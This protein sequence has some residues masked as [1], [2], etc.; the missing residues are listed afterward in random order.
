MLTLL[1]LLRHL[2][3]IALFAWCVILLARVG[4]G[5]LAPWDP[6]RR[7]VAAGPY[8]HVRNPMISSVLMMLSGEAML[9]RS[10]P[11]VAW[12]ARREAA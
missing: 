7:L 9:F 10:W 2:I 6:T 4:Q 1:M 12:A 3:T 11:L 5:T 8:R